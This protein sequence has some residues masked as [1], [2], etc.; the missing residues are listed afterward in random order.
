MERQRSNSP[1]PLSNKKTRR[2]FAIALHRAATSNQLTTFSSLAALY[3]LTHDPKPPTQLI[4]KKKNNISS[5]RR[6]TYLFACN[7]YLYP[8]NICIS[9]QYLIC[10]VHSMTSPLPFMTIFFPNPAARQASLPAPPCSTHPS[11]KPSRNNSSPVPYGISLHRDHTFANL[12]GSWLD[13]RPRSPE[14]HLEEI[15]EVEKK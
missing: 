11:I 3:Q 13:F 1:P 4:I 5:H 7:V 14:I 10:L 2:L 8:S 12:P 6:I 9:R 15:T